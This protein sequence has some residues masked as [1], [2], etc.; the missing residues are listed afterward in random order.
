MMTAMADLGLMRALK[1]PLSQAADLIVRHHESAA[2][3]RAGRQRQA[4]LDLPQPA[5]GFRVEGM[6]HA[7]LACGEDA[8]AVDSR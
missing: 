8:L 1:V 2:D 7:V 5:A 6:H 4:R 3:A